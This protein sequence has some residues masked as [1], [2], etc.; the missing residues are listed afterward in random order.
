MKKDLGIVVFL[1][2]FI[3]G[4]F[5]VFI[6]AFLDEN[7]FNPIVLVVSIIQ[8]CLFLFVFGYIWSFI[9]GIMTLINSQK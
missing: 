5:G 6:S 9:S 1:L 4:P 2:D 8:S 7:G 3:F